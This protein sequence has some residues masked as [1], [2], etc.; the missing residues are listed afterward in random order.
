MNRFVP[1]KSWGFLPVLRGSCVLN[2]WRNPIREESDL[3][4]CNQTVDRLIVIRKHPI[5]KNMFTG[6]MNTNHSIHDGVV[7]LVNKEQRPVP[8]LNEF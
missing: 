4:L 3:Y 6:I 5:N 1:P 7:S 2:K 8:L